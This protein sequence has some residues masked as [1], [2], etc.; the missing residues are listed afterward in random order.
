MLNEIIKNLVKV[1]Q[2][3]AKNYA[4]HAHIQEVIPSI[5]S[6]NFQ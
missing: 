2:D 4:G 1:K 3:F 5:S 6:N